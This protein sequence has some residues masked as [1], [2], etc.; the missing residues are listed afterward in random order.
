MNTTKNN[1]RC[2]HT[3]KE[4]RSPDD[5][6]LVRFGHGHQNPA[7]PPYRRARK[8]TRG[9]LASPWR[10]GPGDR[11]RCNKS[12]NKRKQAVELCAH[13]CTVQ[14]SSNIKY[15]I[16]SKNTGTRQEATR[17]TDVSLTYTTKLYLR[18][19]VTIIK[20]PD[21]NDNGGLTAVRLYPGCFYCCSPRPRPQQ[22]ELSKTIAVFGQ[23]AKRGL[24]VLLYT[25]KQFAQQ[26]DWRVVSHSSGAE[27]FAKFPPGELQ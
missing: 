18:R 10:T 22:T 15:N 6:D 25:C 4:E 17:Y 20:T 1:V 8:R 5:D 2:L 26:C 11:W 13:A 7:H 19:D 24:Y 9:I 21:N 16:I 12:C 3:D 14:Y 27:T 23:A